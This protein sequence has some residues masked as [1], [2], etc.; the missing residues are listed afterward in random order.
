MGVAMK[1]LFKSMGIAFIAGILIILLA[2]LFVVIFSWVQYA[3]SLLLPGI[4]ELVNMIITTL[5]Y[6]TIMG[7]FLIYLVGSLIDKHE[8]SNDGN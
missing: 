7:G 5:C 2:M 8:S 1:N 6:V 3:I 4:S